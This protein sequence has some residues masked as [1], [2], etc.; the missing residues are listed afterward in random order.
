[1][2]FNLAGA[3]IGAGNCTLEVYQTQM[4]G[5]GAYG[6]FNGI[7]LE[8]TNAPP[9]PGFKFIGASQNHSATL[10]AN[11]LLAIAT[12]LEGD[13]MSIASVSGGSTNGGTVGVTSGVITYT[14]T[15]DFV[16]TDAFIYTLSDGNGGSATG[17]VQVNVVADDADYNRLSP[18]TAL[19]AGSSYFTCHGIPGSNYA[20][21]QATNLSSAFYGFRF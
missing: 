19:G 16:G 4:V 3:T 9:V 12:D 13:S 21:D 17:T 1:M 8:A 5:G 18:P 15:T 11:D 6:I 20:L 10:S 14:P 2:V 7:S